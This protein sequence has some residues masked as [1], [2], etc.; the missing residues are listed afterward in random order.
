MAARTPRSASSRPATARS[1]AR[2][3]VPPSASPRRDAREQMILAAER[4]FAERGIGAVSLR[5]IG[6]A[7]GQRNNGAAQ[8]HFGSKR[9]LVDAI[10]EYRMRPVNERRLELLAA[11]DAAGRG[12]D[13]RALVEV[14]VLPFA[15]FVSA[16]ETSWARFLEQAATEPDVDIA[17][18]VQRPA[19]RGLREVLRRLDA[20][21]RDLPPH[22]RRSRIELAQILLVHAGAGWEREASQAPRGRGMGPAPLALDLVD[23]T[24]GLLSAPVT[25][26]PAKRTAAVRRGRAAGR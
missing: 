13:L 20:A 12:E 16:P 23:A 7:A 21:L 22:V 8:Y 19:M 15:E 6:A 25:S 14:L 11:A 3:A 26:A 17:A 10:V 9:G 2:S 18:V 4:L 24:V 1:S 5:E